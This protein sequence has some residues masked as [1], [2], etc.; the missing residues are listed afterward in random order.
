[1]EMRG[2]VKAMIRPERIE[3]EPH[4]TPGDNRLPGLVERAV[5]L[6]GS[7]EVHVRIVGG[8]LLK[9]TVSNN[10]RPLDFALEE[11]S[12][13]TLHLPPSGLR[14]LERSQEEPESTAEA[15]DLPERT[16]PSM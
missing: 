14:V 5:F 8:D 3:L 16:A 1:M 4:D 2:A 12:S 9:A 15:A 6:G 11:G 10:G 13:V 7:H